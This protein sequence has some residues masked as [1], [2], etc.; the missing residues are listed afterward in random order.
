MFVGSNDY[1]DGS[2]TISIVVGAY[3]N[4]GK[5]TI[6]STKFFVLSLVEMLNASFA[7]GFLRNMNRRLAQ[8]K[9]KTLSV[10]QF[11]I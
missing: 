1:S 8:W 9:I 7:V 4:Y 2:S 5:R 3:E 6:I 11:P 10:S